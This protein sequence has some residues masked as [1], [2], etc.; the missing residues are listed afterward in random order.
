M[1]AAVSLTAIR[2]VKSMFSSP[3]AIRNVSPHSE[4]RV[5]PGFFF[6]ICF[7]FNYSFLIII[8]AHNCPCCW[9]LYIIHSHLY[10][11]SNILRERK[12]I[13]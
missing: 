13:W 7:V 4:R 2:F 9:L 1:K 11:S 6:I 8:P 12:S 5:K 10:L 3:S